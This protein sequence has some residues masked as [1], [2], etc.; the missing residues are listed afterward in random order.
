VSFSDNGGIGASRSKSSNRERSST[1]II[2]ER[3][4][5]EIYLPETMNIRLDYLADE[6]VKPYFVVGEE[7]DYVG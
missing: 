6:M 7:V 2:V 3:L 1:F 4:H 5:I